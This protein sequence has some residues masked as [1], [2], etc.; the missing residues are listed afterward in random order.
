[1]QKCFPLEELKISL[2]PDSTLHP[3]GSKDS[4]S[5]KVSK[6]GG[7]LHLNYLRGDG[8]PAMKVIFIDVSG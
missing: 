6:A 4:S 1:M 7:N 5:F 8:V 2:Q 3:L